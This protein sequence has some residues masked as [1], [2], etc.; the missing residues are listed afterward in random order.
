MKGLFLRK[1]KKRLPTAIYLHLFFLIYK[2]SSK[3]IADGG[4][5][6]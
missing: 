5:K 4:E 3:A 2:N 6:L 1:L